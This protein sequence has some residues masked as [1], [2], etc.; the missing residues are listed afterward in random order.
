MVIVNV[1]VLV[2]TVGMVVGRT[3]VVVTLGAI[4]VVGAVT[5]GRGVTEV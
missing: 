1:L 5:V 2:Y 4:E 3:T